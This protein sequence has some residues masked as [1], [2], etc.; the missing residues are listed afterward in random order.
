M[1]EKEKEIGESVQLGKSCP[2]FAKIALGG[3]C[4][5]VGLSVAVR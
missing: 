3:G 2:S 5:A 1:E 4:F